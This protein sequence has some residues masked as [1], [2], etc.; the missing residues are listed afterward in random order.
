MEFHRNYQQLVVVFLIPTINK[1]AVVFNKK[2]M[3]TNQDE[4]DGKSK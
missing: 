3:D 1:N 2:R 4:P